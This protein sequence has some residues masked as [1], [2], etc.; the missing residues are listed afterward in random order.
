MKLDKESLISLFYKYEDELRDVLFPIIDKDYNLEDTGEAPGWVGQ[1]N[2]EEALHYIFIREIR[3]SIAVEIGCWRGYSAKIIG[4]A[5]EQN[6]AGRL[7]GIDNCMVDPHSLDAARGTCEG[8]PVTFKNDDG[9][10]LS[11][12]S[13]TL[14]RSCN[15]I[16]IDADHTKEF[17]LAMFRDVIP[18][19][20]KGTLIAWHDMQDSDVLPIESG[21]QEPVEEWIKGSDYDHVYAR[22][23]V[24][25]RLFL[26]KISDAWDYKERKSGSNPL[27]GTLFV[28]YE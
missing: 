6:G 9:Q 24:R 20:K 28:N 8:L 15:Y 1:G 12:S 26:D 4:T 23:L 17:A 27:D 7:F 11:P 10:H 19:L 25:D 3:P 2:L 14:V 22:S 16:F 13:L 21:E 5:L 18:S